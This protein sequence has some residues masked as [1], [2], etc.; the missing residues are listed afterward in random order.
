MLEGKYNLNLN[1]PM[2]NIPCAL[3]LWKENNSLSGSIEMLGSKN[4]FKRWKNGRK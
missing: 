3:E 1:T 4:Y 2:G